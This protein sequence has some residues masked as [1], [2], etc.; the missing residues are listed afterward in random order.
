M[1]I[2]LVKDMKFRAGGRTDMK[3]IVAIPHIEY[4]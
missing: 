4:G 2:R 1:K 3:L